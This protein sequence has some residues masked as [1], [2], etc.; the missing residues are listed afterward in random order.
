MKVT[1]SSN[2]CLAKFADPLHEGK[3]IWYYTKSLKII[4][5]AVILRC[6]RS[7]NCKRIHLFIYNILE[8]I[9]TDRSALAKIHGKKRI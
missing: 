7:W 6:S 4:G 1:A 5:F 9:V 2:S 8:E 3:K